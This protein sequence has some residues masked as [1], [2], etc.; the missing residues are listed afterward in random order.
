MVFISH[1][2][3]CLSCHYRSRNKTSL[4]RLLG[5][6]DVKSDKAGEKSPKHCL[7]NQRAFEGTVSYES[8]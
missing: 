3:T 1:Q 5:I 2:L 8:D 6:G 4:K 7:N